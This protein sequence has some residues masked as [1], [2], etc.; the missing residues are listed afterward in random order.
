MINKRLCLGIFKGVPP[1]Y[2]PALSALTT[3][4][5]LFCDDMDVSQRLAGEINAGRLDVHGQ[6]ILDAF[7]RVDAHGKMAIATFPLTHRLEPRI[8]RFI[9][10][11]ALALAKKDPGATASLAYVLRDFLLQ[12]PA[13]V[14]S[15]AE[16]I[17]AMSRH[18]NARV[19]E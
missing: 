3:A 7:K 19:I 9:F 2:P 12:N 8:F 17:H 15:Y 6:L 13:Q 18:R 1:R 10:R 16:V 4:L 11:R 14:R 5:C